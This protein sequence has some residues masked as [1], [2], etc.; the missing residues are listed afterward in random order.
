MLDVL[1]KHSAQVIDLEGLA[2]HKGSAFGAIGEE[3]QPTTEHFENILFFKMR[4][5]NIDKTIWLEDESL[6]IGKV[7]IPRPLFLQMREQQIFFIDIP[8]TERAKYLVGTYGLFDKSLL[9]ESIVK[10]TKRLGYDKAQ[11]ALNALKSD[12]LQTVAE[13]TLRYYDKAYLGGLEKRNKETVT[14]I[15]LETVDANISAKVLLEF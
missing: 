7:V 3:E 12:D 2:N 15:P 9:E 5:L 10:I 4:T 8:V 13:I 11:M 14:K 1:I 6:N